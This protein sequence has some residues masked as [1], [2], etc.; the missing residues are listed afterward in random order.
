MGET[1]IKSLTCTIM[2][3]TVSMGTLE[4]RMTGSKSEY[5]ITAS[6]EMGS[7][8][9]SSQTVESDKKIDVSVSMGSLEVTFDN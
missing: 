1:V 5:N 8:N 3:A 9:I 2:N 6:C 4:I 7:S